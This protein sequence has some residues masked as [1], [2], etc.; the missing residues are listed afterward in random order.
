MVTMIFY[1]II[2]L[3]IILVVS[4]IKLM[5]NCSENIFTVAESQTNYLR[6]INSKQGK[7]KF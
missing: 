1:I 2:P 5:K 6:G 4:I 7:I 3:I